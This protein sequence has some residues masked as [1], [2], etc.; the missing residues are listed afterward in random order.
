[1]GNF[2]L[3][4]SHFSGDQKSFLA[5]M[6]PP[7]SV[8]FSDVSFRSFTTKGLRGVFPVVHCFSPLLEE[9]KDSRR[10]TL[11]LGQGVL[12]GVVELVHGGERLLRRGQA[13]RVFDPLND[14]SRKSQRP[15]IGA[16]GF[17]A[18][19]SSSLLRQGWTSV[20]S[21]ESR[22]RAGRSRRTAR[23]VSRG[24]RATANSWPVG[25]GPTQSRGGS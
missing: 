8:S 11:F 1:M 5:L 19:R 16:R 9:D 3:P 4:S 6:T 15:L 2:C 23:A 12:D 18:D 22:G 7:P 17:C 13:G 25:P 20:S 24:R 14:Q 21:W 10:R